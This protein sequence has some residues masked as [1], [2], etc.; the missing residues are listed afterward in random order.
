M[1][2]ELEW[3][4]MEIVADIE[5]VP[6]NFLGVTKENYEHRL[7]LQSNTPLM[8]AKTNLFGVLISFICACVSHRPVN[9]LMLHD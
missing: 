4:R 3:I 6:Q 1:N 9:S 8:Q 5:V 2:N 7:R